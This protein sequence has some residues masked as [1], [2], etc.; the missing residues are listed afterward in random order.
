MAAVPH[1]AYDEFLREVD[2]SLGASVLFR[3]DA[4][5]GRA[6]MTANFGDTEI[7]YCR[8]LCDFNLCWLTGTR[9]DPRRYVYNCMS[10]RGLDSMSIGSP[11]AIIESLEKAS[12][13]PC[14][15]NPKSHGVE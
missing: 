10:N 15:F 2:E 11:D 3:P 6:N 9:V 8:Y 5:F 14:R 7:R 4:E 1:V 13:R 12:M